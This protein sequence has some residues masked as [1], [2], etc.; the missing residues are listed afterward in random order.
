M[1]IQRVHLKIDSAEVSLEGTHDDIVE[2]AYELL[3]RVSTIQPLTK[4]RSPDCAENGENGYSGHSNES[5]AHLA[6]NDIATKELTIERMAEHKNCET[7]GQLAE[8]ACE[9]LSLVASKKEFKRNEILSAIK[10]AP[11]F[12]T[13]SYQS[14]LSNYLKQLVKDGTILKKKKN[15]YSLSNKAV[16]SGERYI[17]EIK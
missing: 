9:Y 6:G 7:G 11:S 14:N 15:C 5:T 10:C 1:T 3:N 4:H 2:V 13:E 12:F 17:V 8:T 16:K